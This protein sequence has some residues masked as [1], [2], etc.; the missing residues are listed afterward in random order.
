MKIKSKS[1][2]KPAVA[3]AAGTTKARANQK[4]PP[5]T[6][7]KKE[8]VQHQT[9]ASTCSRNY[10]RASKPKKQAKNITSNPQ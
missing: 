7:A 3:K 1:N 5:R 2:I 6:G 9:R 8:A 10:P 4:P